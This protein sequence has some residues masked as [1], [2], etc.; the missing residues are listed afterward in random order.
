MIFV[1]EGSFLIKAKKKFG[2]NFLKDESVLEKIIQSMPN[3]DLKV[4]EIGPGLGDLTRK[5]LISG[6]R[7]SAFEID[8]ELCRI[9]KKSFSKELEEGRLTLDCSDILSVWEGNESLLDTK[10]HLIANLP[11]YIATNIILRALRDPNC[12]NL[13]VMVQKEVAYK[14]AANSGD[15]AFSSL[16]VLTKSVAMAEVLFEVS[17]ESFSPPPKVTS[18][19]LKIDKFRD[20]VSK[21]SSTALFEREEEYRSFEAF[22]KTAFKAPRKT[23][24][25]NLSQSF[26]KERIL[27]SFEKLNLPQNIRA[28]Q[29]QVEDYH[30]LFQDIK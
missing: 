19:V 8:M 17:R 30:L 13:M 25:K 23:L 22:L 5:L 29:L 3:D 20:F 16:A 9:L 7:V 21:E 12:T 14:F 28:H 24:L 27:S 6:K 11:Y 15:K 2:Q 1:S 26:D 4:V 10:Y 18:A